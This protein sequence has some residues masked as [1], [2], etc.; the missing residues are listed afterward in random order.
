MYRLR[1]VDPENSDAFRE[2]CLFV[3]V[4]RYII[5]FCVVSDTGQAIGFFF[6]A[7]FQ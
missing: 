7:N 5:P 1:K 3:F 4:H 2:K 6:A